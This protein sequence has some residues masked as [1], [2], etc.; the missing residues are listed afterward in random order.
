M[1]TEAELI[2]AEFVDAIL[3]MRATVYTRAA[4]GQF[5]VV[6]HSGLACL[7]TSL[8]TGAAVSV[9][10]RAALAAQRTFQY[11]ATYDLAEDGVQ[12]AVDAFPGKRWNPVKNTD[13]VAY[14][15]DIGV[16]GKFVT[17]VRAS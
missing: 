12:I 13:D 16:G 14:F 3:T 8:S 5:T 6:L 7:L 17:V 2:N 9:A 11:D 4:N 15:P 1:P 10:D